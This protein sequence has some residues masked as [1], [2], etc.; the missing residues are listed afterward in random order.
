MNELWEKEKQERIANRPDEVT[1]KL[2]DWTYD[3]KRNIFWGHVYGDV[4]KRFDDGEYIHTSLV[5]RVEDNKVYTLNSIYELGE[6]EDKRNM[7]S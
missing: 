5:D 4:R 6:L 7:D 1:A 2:E 3:K